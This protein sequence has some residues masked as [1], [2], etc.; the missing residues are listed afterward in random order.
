MPAQ[1]SQARHKDHLLHLHPYLLEWDG[2]ELWFTLLSTISISVPEVIEIL[3]DVRLKH[4]S[5]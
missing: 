3:D 4:D 1:H 2:V 5:V